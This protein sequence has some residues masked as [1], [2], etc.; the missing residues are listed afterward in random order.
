MFVNEKEKTE[1]SNFLGSWTNDQKNN[2][3]VFLKLRDNIMEKE[4]A[5]LNFK[6]R[7]GVS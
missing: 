4:N 2:K 3:G 7:P 6:S 5:V 1:F